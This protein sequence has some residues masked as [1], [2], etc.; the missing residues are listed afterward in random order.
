MR[1]TS[2]IPEGFRTTSHSVFHLFE[3]IITVV[4]IVPVHGY[5]DNES[6]KRKADDC[7][8]DKHDNNDKHNSSDNNDNN[9]NDAN[10]DNSKR[11]ETVID[12]G[13]LVN[14]STTCAICL[15]N[16]TKPLTLLCKH[17]YC[18]DCI[19]QYFKTGNIICP[20]CKREC[21]YYIQSNTKQDKVKIWKIYQ[22]TAAN[23]KTT[24]NTTIPIDQ[25]NSSIKAHIN[26]FHCT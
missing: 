7:D 20:I 9:D 22:P 1:K 10:N 6:R 25:F 16:Y 12:T 13:D 19:Q 3:P 21:S 23:D 26:S 8:N 17:S 2:L 4:Y 24:I 15:E 5:I 11:D 14:V 18:Q